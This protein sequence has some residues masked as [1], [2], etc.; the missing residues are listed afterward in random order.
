MNYAYFLIV[1][2]LSIVVSSFVCLLLLLSPVFTFEKIRMRCINVLNVDEDN[3]KNLRLVD[4]FG[5]EVEKIF[6][7]VGHSQTF[8]FEAEEPITSMTVSPDL[9]DGL[10]LNMT[11][12]LYG[13][14][15]KPL[16]KT[17]FQFKANSGTLMTSIQIT[18]IECPYGV[19]T[20]IGSTSSAHLTVSKEDVV[21]LDNISVSAENIYCLEPGFYHY[22]L[23]ATF[24][25]IG[26]YIRSAER[27]IHSHYAYPDFSG[28][29]QLDSTAAP[30]IKLPYFI[31]VQ[32]SGVRLPFQI[33][34]GFTKVTIEPNENIQ[35]NPVTNMLTFLHSEDGLVEY[36]MTAS[37]EIGST[38]A[39]FM[40]GVNTCKE[41]AKMISFDTYTSF[42]SSFNM[43]DEEGN[44]MIHRWKDI[45]TPGFFCA[46][47]DVSYPF[48]LNQNKFSEESFYF[49]FVDELGVLSEYPLSQPV[50]ES[51]IFT[52]I[53]PYGA[54][55]LY[56][57]EKR[58]GWMKKSI[59]ETSWKKGKSGEWGEWETDHRAY[60]RY[61]FAIKNHAYSTLHIQVKTPHAFTVY[62]NEKQISQLLQPNNTSLHRI[63]IPFSFL[64][65]DNVLAI[66]LIDAVQ[67][68]SIEFDMQMIA[69]QTSHIEVSR[70]G[71]VE[72][73]Q[74]EPDP[75]HPAVS[76][77]LNDMSYW[78]ILKVPAT[79]E[80]TFG[81]AQSVI[82]NAFYYGSNED[83]NKIKSFS[84]EGVNEEK[85]VLLLNVTSSAMTSANYFDFDNETPFSM[86]RITITEAQEKEELD[87]Y[88][89]RLLQ[90]NVQVCETKYG[91]KGARVGESFLA[92]C[93]GDKVGKLQVKCVSKNAQAVW[94]ENSSSCVSR[95]PPT[96][97]AFV[98]FTMV[99]TADFEV[100]D[101]FLKTDV[102]KV[103][104]EF[105]K[106]DKKQISY[107]YVYHQPV[108]EKDVVAVAVRFTVDVDL[109]DFIGKLFIQ[110]QQEFIE[111]M[112]EKEVDVEISENPVVYK[113]EQDVP[114][115]TMLLIFIIIALIIT[116]IL[117][118]CCMCCCMCCK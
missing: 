111:K 110:Q 73:I 99:I 109:G 104:S 106:V 53:A 55:L 61:H 28:S 64:E 87:I 83:D 67:S 20:I 81:E 9:P 89:F 57:K 114:D 92:S 63:S 118:C 84:I 76:A 101:Y 65:E 95:T 13:S 48:Q 15:L 56:C 19:G 17:T 30:V 88:H 11:G 23:T 38:S 94:E 29:F 91:I 41:G 1:F 72:S 42:F 3:A 100:T 31:P 27:F 4:S 79:A 35:Y 112:N 103:I 16:N 32:Q 97:M 45:H 2:Q 80:Y 60:F 34:G 7:T 105:S 78:K 96:D 18:I 74:Q 71:T 66:E 68:D 25:Y 10:T 107:V 108:V 77:F 82:A 24:D 39:V 43:E 49:A 21:V 33:E 98:D 36:T 102:L 46:Y 6:L 22:N 5:I 62:C 44:L 113:D 37:N 54:P 86:Y 75:L 90:K 116:N 40:V 93:E 117:T 69:T 8:H 47:S 52:Q 85:T 50:E 70:G 51:F 26:L 58:D 14:P 12:I 115:Y 59:D